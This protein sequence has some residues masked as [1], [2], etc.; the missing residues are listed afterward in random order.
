[1]LPL[2]IRILQ[3]YP[4]LEAQALMGFDYMRGRASYEALLA[5]YPDASEQMQLGLLG[6]MGR[7]KDPIFLPLLLENATGDDPARR[8]LGFEALVQSELAGGVDAICAYVESRPEDDRKFDIENLLAYADAMSH[9]NEKSAAGKAYLTLY[10]TTDND[11]FREIAFHG[12]KEFPSPE[13]YK[14]ILADIDMDNLS[15]VSIDTLIA[16]NAML[17]PAEHPAE[18]ALLRTAM[19]D[20][21]R[22]PTHVQSILDM[23]HQQGVGSEVV[24]MMGFVTRWHLIG[25]FP[26]S[27]GEGFDANPV[28]A[29]Q[30][31]LNA[32]YSVGDQQRTWKQHTTGQIV[33][34]IGLLG[35]HGNVSLYA[36]ANI[37]SVENT[38]AQIRLGSD[39]GV[40]VWLNGESVHENNIDR[41]MLLDQDIVPV[42]LKKGNNELLVQITQGGGGWGFM[43]RFT[44]M[45]G[46]PIPTGVKN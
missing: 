18:V 7:K 30:I 43:L 45:D 2:T 37:Q 28:N 38:D 22:T 17:D 36:Y 39:D 24:A 1:M 34:A 8:A 40:R 10:R 4:E 46:S 19:L 6:V 20:A 14:I 29:P 11:E 33:N 41:G 13:A 44:K 35:Q 3:K 25:P 23:A 32:T 27:S 42:K 16:L 15:E 5:A 9:K 21:A 26:W 31:D 12:V